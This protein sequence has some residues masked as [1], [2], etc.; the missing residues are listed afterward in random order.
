VDH[1]RQTIEAL[2]VMESIPGHEI[3]DI[4]EVDI[5]SDSHLDEDVGIPIVISMTH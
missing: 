5:D 1:Q 4:L 3:E 2:G